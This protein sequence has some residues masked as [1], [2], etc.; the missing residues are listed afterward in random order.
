MIITPVPY[1]GIKAIT[2]PKAVGYR[3]MNPVG[4]VGQQ[5]SPLILSTAERRWAARDG[6]RQA[7]HASSLNPKNVDGSSLGPRRVRWWLYRAHWGHGTPYAFLSRLRNIQRERTGRGIHVV[8]SPN[9][10]CGVATD[11]RRRLCVRMMMI[12]GGMPWGGSIRRRALTGPVKK[13]IRVAVDRIRVR[14][15]G[16]RGSRKVSLIHHGDLRCY[17]MGTAAS[18]SGLTCGPEVSVLQSIVSTPLEMRGL[19]N[20]SYCY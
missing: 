18:T 16:K 7:V 14:R 11:Q 3:T 4:Q 5:V 10:E 19:Q 8:A 1:E 2:S 9:V 13:S 15:R 12:Y 17:W 20:V 6:A